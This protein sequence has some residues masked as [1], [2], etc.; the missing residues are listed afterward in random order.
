MHLHPSPLSL[1]Y[2]FLSP[3]FSIFLFLCSLSAH[4]VI[5]YPSLS[6]SKDGSNGRV[7]GSVVQRIDHST[8]PLLFPPYIHP[9]HFPGY[10]N[11]GSSERLDKWTKFSDTHIYIYSAWLFHP[12]NG[13]REREWIKKREGE[14]NR[15]KRREKW[16]DG[17]NRH[18]VS[19][20]SITLHSHSPSSC[21]YHSS[22]KYIS[23]FPF[24]IVS[25]EKERKTDRESEREKWE[26]VRK[27][28]GRERKRLVMKEGE[29]VRVGHKSWCLLRST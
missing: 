4:L 14:M 27:K 5:V 23:I 22:C 1:S 11:C 3:P 2:C 6:P 7:D 29:K 26:R 17:M 28:N 24:R 12:F 16:E 10:L 20:E 19:Q 25:I 18:C 13:K 8:F 15:E 9:L 21:R